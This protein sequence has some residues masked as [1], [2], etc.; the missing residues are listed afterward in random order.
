MK[1]VL[2]YS[3]GTDS[4]LIKELWNPDIL[5]YVDLD[6]R[7][8]ESEIRHIIKETDT[9]VTYTQLPLGQFEDL[10]TAFIPQRNLYL[11]MMACHYGEHICLGATKEDIGG[12]SDKDEEFLSEAEHLLQRLWKPQSLYAGKQ[13][14]VEKEF[15]NYTKNDMIKMYLDRGGD[16]N[17]FRRETFSCY[18]PIEKEECLNC[19]ACFRKFVVCYG[20]GATY[21]KEELEKVYRFA[22]ENVVHRSHHAVGRYF[23]DKDNGQEVLQVLKKLYSELG[24]ELSLD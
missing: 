11:L 22:E 24:R 20:N 16:I 4:W 17:R 3:G 10:E 8:S 6:S 19:K 13:I 15:I 18:T 5:L 1:K 21:S 12:S 23:L 7:Y 2:L 14:K 9:S